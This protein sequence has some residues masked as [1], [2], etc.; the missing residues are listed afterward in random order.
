MLDR[1]LA[2]A[3]VISTLTLA[4]TLAAG[5]ARAEPPAPPGPPAAPPAPAAEALP[6]PVMPPSVAAPAVTKL[7]DAAPRWDGRPAGF[8]LGYSAPPGQDIPFEKQ[9]TYPEEMR[10]RSAGMVG[11]GVVLLSFGVIGMF[12]G[13]AMIGAHEPIVD[14]PNNC[15][16]CGGFEDSGGG[17]NGSSTSNVVLKPGF[18]SAGIATLIGSAVAIGA[19]IPLI[20]I[21]AKKVHYA[22]A[23]SPAASAAMQTPSLH[24]GPTGATVIWQF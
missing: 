8:D 11:G 23:A 18:Q 24:V 22:D 10:M 7:P 20:V 17:G 14:Q 16:D 3:L 21:G 9:P 4:A 6:P 15:F 19:A 1:G 2:R 13:S 12:A 5:S